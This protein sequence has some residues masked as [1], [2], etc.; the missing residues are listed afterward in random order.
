MGVHG[1]PSGPL[2][3]KILLIVFKCVRGLCSKNLTIR[4]KQ[5]NCRPEDELLLITTTA[6]TKYGKRTFDYVGP[7]LWNAIHVDVRKIEKV[8]VFKK[9]VKTILFTNTVGFKNRAFRYGL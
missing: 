8:E 4:Y 5:Y 2:D 6:K 7:R 3:Y 1:D 9:R